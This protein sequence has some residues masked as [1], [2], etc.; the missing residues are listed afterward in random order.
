MNIKNK[1][2]GNLILQ[3]ILPLITWGIYT[4][5]HFSN[6]LGNHSFQ[7]L[8]VF[9]IVFVFLGKQI[10]NKGKPNWSVIKIIDLILLG[11]LWLVAPTISWSAIWLLTIN[12]VTINLLFV[13]NLINDN[14]SEWL[15]FSLS[16]GT[17]IVM[18]GQLLINNFINSQQLLVL[19]ILIFSNLLFSFPHF[20][21]KE[22]SFLV[23]ISI[24][25]F[26]LIFGFALSLSVEKLIALALIDLGFLA[27]ESQ[28][29]LLKL[30]IKWPVGLA[31]N[32]LTSLVIFILS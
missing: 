19:I 3:A 28:P 13:K 26:I 18:A 24:I 17:G 23:L 5:I 15:L 12:V 7:L 16:Y 30:S 20:I 4:R 14:Y 31:F 6:L 29:N 2:I 32:L 9:A 25:C 1:Q 11:L 27:I 10:S 8:T 22:P 21:K